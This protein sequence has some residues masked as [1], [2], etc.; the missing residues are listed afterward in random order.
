MTDIRLAGFAAAGAAAAGA[1]PVGA[2]FGIGRVPAAGGIVL[3]IDRALLFSASLTDFSRIA[4][5]LSSSFARMGTRSAGI[6]LFN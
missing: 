1:R 3:P 2:A 5:C 6:G 4:F